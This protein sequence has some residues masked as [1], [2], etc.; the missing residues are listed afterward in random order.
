MIDIIFSLE[1]EINQLRKN[2][3]KIEEF[4]E[5]LLHLK[6]CPLCGQKINEKI[7]KKHL[8]HKKIFN[9]INN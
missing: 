6:K 5:F 4:I 1:E 9:S 8:R 3:K 7:L 2:K